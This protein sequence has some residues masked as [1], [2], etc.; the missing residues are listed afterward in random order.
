M[1]VMLGS[2]PGN[3]YDGQEANSENEAD[4]ES[5]LL[6]KNTSQIGKDFRSLINTDST[7]KCGHTVK[8]SVA[9]I[10]EIVSKMTRKLEEKNIPKFAYT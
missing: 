10:S 1:D 4:L 6:H 2:F 5:I 3:N 7:E 9:I 8:T